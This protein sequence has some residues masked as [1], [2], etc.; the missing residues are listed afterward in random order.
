MA[1]I[2]SEYSGTVHINR[3]VAVI[4][5]TWIKCSCDYYVRTS[6]VLQPSLNSSLLMESM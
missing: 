6:F 5:N 3:I 1:D 2:Q 4:K